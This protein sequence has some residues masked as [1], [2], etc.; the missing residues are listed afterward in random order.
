[1]SKKILFILLYSSCLLHAS[2]NK[3]VKTLDQM[4]QVVRDEQEKHKSAI[5][6]RHQNPHIGISRSNRI[7]QSD[8]VK[9]NQEKK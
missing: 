7:D 6:N 3:P 4:R 1:M 8:P 2:E 9:H 5:Y